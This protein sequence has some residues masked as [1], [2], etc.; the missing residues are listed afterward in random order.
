M[1]PVENLCSSV[2]A[3]LHVMAYDPLAD[4]FDG[5]IRAAN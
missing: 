2:I 4:Y 3:L 1:S 5:G